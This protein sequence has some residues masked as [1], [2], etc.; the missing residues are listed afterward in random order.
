MFFENELTRR[1]EKRQENIGE[2]LEVLAE[3]IANLIIVNL[4]TDEIDNN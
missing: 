3:I 1:E 2:A 4:K